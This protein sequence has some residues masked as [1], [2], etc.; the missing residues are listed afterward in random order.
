MCC[1]PSAPAA[2]QALQEA[3]LPAVGYSRLAELGNAVDVMAEGLA[4]SFG[5][6]PHLGAGQDDHGPTQD[7]HL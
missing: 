7:G 2:S 1:C 4:V 5:A 3:R 6:M